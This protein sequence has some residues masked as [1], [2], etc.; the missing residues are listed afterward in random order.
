MRPAAPPVTAWAW[1]VPTRP[2]SLTGSRFINGWKDQIAGALVTRTR[3][4]VPPNNPGSLGTADTVDVVAY[5]FHHNGFP[6]GAAELSPDSASLQNIRIV[7]Q[8]S[9]S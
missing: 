1:K 4:T 5:I 3:T 2:P 6:T 7:P 9:G 8:G